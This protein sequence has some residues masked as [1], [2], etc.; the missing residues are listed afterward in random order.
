MYS[1]QLFQDVKQTSKGSL[2]GFKRKI[3][4]E[5]SD[6]NVGGNYVLKTKLVRE[7]SGT[8][9]KIGGFSACLSVYLP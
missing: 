7:K 6:K 4:I 3:I 9:V 5:L 2:D 1:S 8:I